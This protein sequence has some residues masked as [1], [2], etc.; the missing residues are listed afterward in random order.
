[1]VIADS[2]GC[3]VLA[4]GLGPIIG[5]PLSETAGRKAIYVGAASVGGLFTLGAGFTTS[6]AGLCVLRFFAGFA[7][8]PSL[9]IG[10]GFLAET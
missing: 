10:S 8:G 6:F 9:A 3:S 4:L 1:M 5:G 7:Y 2:E